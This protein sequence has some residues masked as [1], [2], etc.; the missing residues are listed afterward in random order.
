LQSEVKSEKYEDLEKYRY[1]FDYSYQ[2]KKYMKVNVATGQLASA[3][4]TTI[5]SDSYY[6]FDRK[7]D[8]HY[9][10]NFYTQYFSKMIYAYTI[11]MEAERKKQSN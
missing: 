5:K 1:V 9:T 4:P 10:S 8:K 6:L 11:G 7:E 3:I 2:E